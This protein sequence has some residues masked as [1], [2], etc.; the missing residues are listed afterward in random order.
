MNGGQI[1]PI[2]RI[3]DE[4]K[5]AACPYYPFKNL[6]CI[7]REKIT[8]LQME[9][10]KGL[11]KVGLEVTD[12]ETGWCTDPCLVRYLKATKWDVDQAIDRLINTLT[13]R[14]EYRPDHIDPEEVAPEAETGKEIISG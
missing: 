10:P 1:L 11:K 14:R 7:H 13:W 6:D 9:W 12:Y 3:P 4:L 2:L 8:K 5:P